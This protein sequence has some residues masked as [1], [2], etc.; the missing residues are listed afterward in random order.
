MRRSAERRRSARRALYRSG[1][2][3]VWSLC[4]QSWRKWS[5]ISCQS[6]VSEKHAAEDF[7]E[8]AR[9]EVLN[10]DAGAAGLRM[11]NRGKAEGDCTPGRGV[12]E[13]SLPANI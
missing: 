9:V 8:D 12:T 6:S 10:R 1:H 2:P 11:T 5:V 13:P 3:R 7:C 4:G